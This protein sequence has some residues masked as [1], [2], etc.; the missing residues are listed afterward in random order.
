MDIY[1]IKD[2]EFQ[3]YGKVLCLDTSEIVTEAEKIELPKAGSVYTASEP[4]FEKLDIAATIREEC[5]GQLPTQVGY[6]YGHSKSLNGLEWHKCSEIN[7][8]VTDLI[9]L[10]GNVWDVVD[11]RYNSENV[12]AFRLEKG[13]AVEIYSTTLH[14]CPIETDEKGFGCVVA[15]LEG[16]N[17][18]LDVETNDKLL[19]RKNKWIIAHE[20][21]TALI[22]RGVQAGIYGPNYTF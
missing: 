21:N 4:S 5:F 15:L 12:K 11:G 17:L 6:C 9:L 16:T 14:F 22:D 13:D 7:I 19:F 10:L 3:K 8:A 18:P 1:S 20:E 2:K